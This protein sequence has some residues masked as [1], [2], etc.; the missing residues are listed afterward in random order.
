MGTVTQVRTAHEAQALAD[1]LNGDARKRPMVVVTIPAGKSEPWID[2]QEIAD[3]A[4]DLAEV[5]LM[6]TG[7]V[8][9]AMAQRM[10]EGTEVCSRGKTRRQESAGRCQ[11][12]GY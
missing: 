3:Q 6:P 7:A 9:W 2:V 4:G 5:Y 8:S 11:T 12:S 10:P 1:V